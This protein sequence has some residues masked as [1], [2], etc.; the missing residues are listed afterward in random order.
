MKWT[1]LG[2]A[3]ACL[4]LLVAGGLHVLPLEEEK[5]IV[6]GTTDAVS[7]NDPAGAYDVGSWTL[8]SNVYQSLLT[9]KP[10][11]PVPQPDAAQ[12]CRFAGSDLMTYR[13]RL[14]DGLRFSNGHKV[15]AAAVKHSF[16]RILRIKAPHGPGML[17]SSLQS[18][19]AQGSTVTF[20]L[21][22]PDAT[23]P[24]KIATGAGSIVDPAEFPADRLRTGTVVGSGRYMVSSYTENEEI[25]LK[26]NPR[27]K[28]SATDEGIPVRIR[29]Y[30]T[31][32][33]LE[34]AWRVRA[35]DV[36]HR[37]LPS[38]A[39][40]EMDQN[41][42]R[43]R[44]TTLESTETQ[45]LVLN[46]G[47]GSPMAHLGVRRAVAAVV[48]RGR[49]TTDAFQNTVTPLYS[50]VP[51]GVAGHNTAFFDAYPTP[52][53]RR[54]RQL[55]RSAD[56]ALPVTFT[57][58]HREGTGAVEARELKRQLEASGLF[59]VELRG[60]A[61]WKRFQKRYSSGEFDAYTLGWVPDYPD[62]DTFIQGLVGRNNVLHTGY[63]SADIDNL[64]RET[65]RHSERGSA[66]SAFKDIQREVVEDVPLIP[67]WQRKDHVVT[68]P[69]VTGA[70]YLT[71]G[72]GI[73]RLWKLD[74]L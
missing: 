46:D 72:T 71:D 60:E 19:E 23:W 36:V 18:V 57:L 74:R 26:P 51:Q 40:A 56:V 37:G 2:L 63:T 17:L 14:R 39:L 35:V 49:L 69:E 42:P 10:G 66:M 12:D 1:R 62:P 44:L 3:A 61:D 47:E 68:T 27:Y 20:H 48:D 55:L 64:I 45:N 53:S 5:P 15:T 8:Y 50:V 11:S 59:R 25:F 73:Y 21:K 4:A 33:D 43:I 16:D 52:D 9:F 41:D 28:G 31:A 24:S 38:R 32:Q 29:Y 58:G 6:I 13:C 54:A 22:A 65:Q 67:L 34:A 70:H 7:H 30:R